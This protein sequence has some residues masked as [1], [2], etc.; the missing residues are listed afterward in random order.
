[1]SLF[2]RGSEDGGTDVRWE[3]AD[4]FDEGGDLP[5][6]LVGVPLTVYEHA[7]A[8]EAVLGDPENLGFREV[9]SNRRELGRGGNQSSGRAALAWFEIAMAAGTFRKIDFAAG[10][11]DCIGG[12]KGIRYLRSVAADGSANGG[13]QEI[14]FK[15]R[16]WDVGADFGEA[17]AEIG[18]DGEAEEEKGCEDAEE[19]G[20][21]GGSVVGDELVGLDAADWDLLLRVDAAG[22]P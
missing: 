5:E 15:T 18:E 13:A 9:G 3:G 10:D 19:E 12:R 1:L 21:H 2:W 17:E 7:G 20:F 14:R 4:A 22:R 8:A 11:K 6:S 16:R